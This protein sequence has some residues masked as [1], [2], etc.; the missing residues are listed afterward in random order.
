MKVRAALLTVCVSS[1]WASTTTATASCDFED[2]I[3]YASGSQKQ[4]AGWPK[5]VP[6]KEECCSACA[7]EPG[8][9]AGVWGSPPGPTA[10][11][12][13]KDAEDIKKKSKPRCAT[14][15]PPAAAAASKPACLR[16]GATALLLARHCYCCLHSRCPVS[17]VAWAV[18][19][20]MY[21]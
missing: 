7:A 1:C 3:D 15:L 6:T 19:C 14:T 11:C 8:C 13:Y 5:T 4:P 17:N 10:Q 2:N 21:I 9:A 20:V 12:W 18:W 16:S